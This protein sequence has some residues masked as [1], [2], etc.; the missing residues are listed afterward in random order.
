M[1]VLD[2]TAE[3]SATS[4][5]IADDG[6]ISRK[7]LR[8]QLC[9][10]FNVIEAKSGLDVINILK[11]QSNQISCILLDIL[12]PKVDGI[13]VLEFMRENG[14]DGQI[15][16]I[17]VT[18][19]S[20]TNGKLACYE[21]GAADIIEKPYDH[22]ILLNRV[23]HYIDLYAR[24]REAEMRKSAA[25]DATLAR[26]AAVLDSLPQAVFAFDNATFR[27]NYCNAVF[28]LIPGMVAQPVGRS[29]AEVFKP[30]EYA[31]ILSAVS[32]LLTARERVPV[33]IQADGMTLSLLFNAITDASGN[34]ADI[35]GTVANL[36]PAPAS[37][38][39]AAAR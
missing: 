8:A 3:S 9:K 17:A 4:V 29:L 26:N 37:E 19:I 30:A 12:M 27:I 10:V 28:P 36:T 33:E 22:R 32:R 38:A 39:T 6:D 23:K 34:V 15:P 16:V 14:L 31:A 13:K 21:A 20:D 25:A 5:L 11:T 18:G 7:M 35:V 24:I 2:T 1:N